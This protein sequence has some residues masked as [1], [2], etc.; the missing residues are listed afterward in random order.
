MRLFCWVNVCTNPWYSLTCVIFFTE[1]FILLKTFLFRFLFLLWKHARKTKLSLRIQH[2]TGCNWNTNGHFG[3][4]RYTVDIGICIVYYNATVD[5]FLSA[6]SQ[7][8]KMHSHCSWSAAVCCR[9]NGDILQPPDWVSA[10]VRDHSLH[11]R[12]SCVMDA[13]ISNSTHHGGFGDK[14]RPPEQGRLVLF[15]PST[16]NVWQWPN[17]QT[18]FNLV[19]SLNMFPRIVRNN[20]RISRIPLLILLLC[21]LGK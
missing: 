1:V 7:C 21:L 2:N 12:G 16:G 5:N 17:V 9:H 19:A 18:C 4:W 14:P 13:T 15:P 8:H 11:C 6:T 10:G 3:G 20:M